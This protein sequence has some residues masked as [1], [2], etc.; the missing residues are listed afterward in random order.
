MQNKG[1]EAV[2]FLST[3]IVAVAVIIAAALLAA[4]LFGLQ[5]F[6]VESNS[7]APAYPVDSFI[8]V[9]ETAPEEIK[10]GDV[11]TYVFN[12]DGLLITHRVVS[13]D[14]EHQTFVT[15]GDNNNVADPAPVMWGNVVGK[16]VF[17]VPKV[18]TVM[19]V[20]TA[21]KN[22]PYIIASVAIIGIASVILDLIEK[23]K[24]KSKN[25]VECIEKK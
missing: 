14:A 8:F 21:D 4:K 13:V 16:V 23:K 9:K 11:V 10:A 22:K 18:G 17:S 15:K 6:T 7:M 24:S 3:F 2:S 19:R 25:E 1:K 5:G 12:N 20:L